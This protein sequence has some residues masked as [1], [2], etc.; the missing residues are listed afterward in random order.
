MT[1]NQIIMR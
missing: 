1:Y